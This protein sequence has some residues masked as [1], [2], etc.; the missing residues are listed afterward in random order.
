MLSE[1]KR[2]KESKGKNNDSGFCDPPSDE[3]GEDL[4][5]DPLLENLDSI[6]GDETLVA[7]F[8]VSLIYFLQQITKLMN[9][10]K[11]GL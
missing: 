1:R 7:Y 2:K 4:L 11:R 9:R 10:Q 6:Q 8:L 5:P 3:G